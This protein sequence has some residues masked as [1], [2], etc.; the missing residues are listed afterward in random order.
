MFSHSDSAGNKAVAITGVLLVLS[1]ATANGEEYT[2]AELE[3]KIAGYSRMQSGGTAMLSGGAVLNCIS[4]IVFVSGVV[5]ASNDKGADMWYLDAPEG[6]GRI[7]LGVVGFSVS[8]LVTAGGI[9][10]RSIAARKKRE[11]KK[12]LKNVSISVSPGKVAVTLHY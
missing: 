10:I 2:K 1:L 11:Y 7:I 8:A 4:I 3:E 12:M 9:A 5:S 6:T